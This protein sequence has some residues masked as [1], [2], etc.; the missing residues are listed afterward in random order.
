MGDCHQRCAMWYL[1]V[2]CAELRRLEGLAGVPASA[3]VSAVPPMPVPETTRACAHGE[4]FQVCASLK[5]CFLPN[6]GEQEHAKSATC[7]APVGYEQEACLP[8]I[9]FLTLAVTA[10]YG[11]TGKGGGGGQTPPTPAPPRASPA[12]MECRGSYVT[13]PAVG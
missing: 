4:V 11:L 6:D 8:Q 10:K 13:D 9:P 2:P 7:T 1:R 12:S 3:A 5:I